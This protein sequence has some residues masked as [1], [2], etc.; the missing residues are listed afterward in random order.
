MNCTTVREELVALLDG[1]LDEGR[2]AELRGHVDGCADCARHLQAE[3]ALRQRLRAVWLDDAMVSALAD[4]APM[5]RKMLTLSSAFDL[6][7]REVAA[8]M[9]CS[10]G[11]VRTRLARAHRRLRERLAQPTEPTRRALETSR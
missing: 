10:A 9:G 3:R 2:R 1:E 4:I 7:Y 8:E 6:N 11:E 5:D